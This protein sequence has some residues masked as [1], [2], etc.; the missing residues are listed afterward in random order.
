[1][2][3]YCTNW[4]R[5]EDHGKSTTG[6]RGQARQ[7][8]LQPY[9]R[10]PPDLASTSVF[11]LPRPQLLVLVRVDQDQNVAHPQLLS[12]TNQLKAG[13]GLTIVGS[14]LDGTFLDNH[15]QVQ[16]AEEVCPAEPPLADLPLCPA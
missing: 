9:R 6:G 12:L 7:A 16:R 10:C 13:K 4:H 14:V 8:T 5:I 2:G 11:R 1:M 3:D 15:L